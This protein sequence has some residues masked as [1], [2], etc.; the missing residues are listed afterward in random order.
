MF[1]FIGISLF[2]SLVSFAFL[3]SHLSFCYLNSRRIFMMQCLNVFSLLFLTL[4][5]YVQVN[6]LCLTYAFESRLFFL[7]VDLVF[8]SIWL[9]KLVYFFA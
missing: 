8:F 9:F 7:N 2:F 3:G 1:F 5:F 6:A 4:D